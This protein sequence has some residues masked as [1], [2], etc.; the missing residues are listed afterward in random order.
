[1]DS[2]D[3]KI[4]FV[5]LIA[6]LLGFGGL[7]LVFSDLGPGEGAFL[8][9]TITAA[10]FF[11][12]GGII[13]FAHF[14]GWLIAM[15]VAWGS[16]LMGG[17]IIFMAIARYGRESFAATDPPYISSGLIILVG[18]LALTLLGGVFGRSLSRW[19]FPTR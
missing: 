12:S 16:V 4:P 13:G 19:Q 1:M 11:L 3:R 8:R 14:K 15:L 10:Y 6:V 9:V 17:F 7:L 5:V 2:I 18:S